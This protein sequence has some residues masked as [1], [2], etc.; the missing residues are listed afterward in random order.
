MPIAPAGLHFAATATSAATG[1]YVVHFDTAA[2]RLV[3]THRDHPTQPIFASVV[4]Q[5][6]V[7]FGRGEDR[8]RFARGSFRI[9]DRLQTWHEGSVIDRI[10]TSAG[11][12]LV[13]GP[14]HGSKLRYQ[15]RFSAST[16]GSLVLD[17]TL[18]GAG[19]GAVL[20]RVRLTTYS[21]PDEGV[22]GFGAQ[23]SRLDMKGHCVPIWSQEQGHGRGLQPLSR[24]IDFVS[25]GT[26]GSWHSTYTAVPYYLTTRGRGFTLTGYEYAEFDLRAPDRIATTVFAARLTARLYVGA[27]P[28]EVLQAHTQ[29]CG[30]MG[31]LPEWIQRGAIVRAGGGSSAVRARVERLRAADVPLAAVWIEDWCGKRHTVTGSRLWWN[32]E[33]DANLYPDWPKLIAELRAS[34]VRV[35]TYF[36]PFLVDAQRKRN[37]R[38]NLFR[39][40]DRNGLL[41]R[42]HR[43]RPYLIGQGGFRAALVDLSNPEARAWLG[44]I[45]ADQIRLGISG[46]MNDFGEALPPD[47]ILHSGAD[48]R[49]YHNRFVEDWA[50]VART[51]CAEADADGDVVFFS[52]SGTT[53]SPGISSLFWLGDQTV[54]WDAYDGLASVVLGLISSGLSGFALNH[55]DI[56]GYFS[57]NL[58]GLR[59]VRGRELYQRWAE[60]AAFTAAFRTHDTNQPQVNHHYDSDPETLAHFAKMARL[61]AALAPY[62]QQLM[63]T[64]MHD[65]LPLVRHMFLEFP[66]D[67]EA[68]HLER[69]FML[70]PDL[71]I[72]PVLNAGHRSVKLYLPQGSWQHVWSRRIHES[73]G[74]WIEVEA[75]LGEPAV[76]LRMGTDVADRIAHFVRSASHEVASE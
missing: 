36:N 19:D 30:R 60:L 63:R 5:A 67:R 16:D 38:R 75:P 64:A 45:M 24:V 4:G 68:R 69:Q 52:R 61:F 55:T 13:G 31:E 54:T 50:R 34:G 57:L 48:P 12:V 14:L 44:A 6:F 40:A 29:F 8:F 62:R 72:A 15:L 74:Q 70:G 2:Q 71:L 53:K 65:G 76:F 9:S 41:V 28:A 18:D 3:V 35:L 56:G 37:H 11:D 47:C 27:S 51:A 1:S 22:F 25:P 23:Y 26:A 10:E 59:Y 46:W 43:R 20:N 39:E 17:I 21:E 58:P 66:A 42:N 73:A 7:A 32:W 33:A 49:E